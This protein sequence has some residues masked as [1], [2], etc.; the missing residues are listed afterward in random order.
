[1]VE[2]FHIST[3]NDLALAA[4]TFAALPQG[5]VESLFT[6]DVAV[7]FIF[8]EDIVKGY[9]TMSIHIPGILK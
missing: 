6:E 1:M 3:N 4:M 8:N 5:A 9:Y 2:G 7:N